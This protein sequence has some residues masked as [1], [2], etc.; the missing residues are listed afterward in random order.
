MI[1]FAGLGNPGMKYDRSR[2]NAGFDCIDYLSALYRIPVSRLKFNSLIGNGLI[3]REKVLLIKPQTYMNNSGEAV[4]AVMDFYRL[5]SQN[6]V[7]IY[8]DIDLDLGVIR[9]RSKGSAGSHNGMKSIIY[10]MGTDDFPRIRVGIGKPGFHEDLVSY[11]LGKHNQED[12][13]IVNKAVE[14]VALAVG[15]LIVAGI[16]TAMSKYNG[17]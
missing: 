6:L 9:I 4:K 1:V 12:Q 15:E 14:K 16:E 13:C 8:D 11:V 10:H 2:H 7:V 5:E 3:Q 17:K